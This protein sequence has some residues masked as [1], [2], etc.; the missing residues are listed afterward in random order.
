MA[1]N[2]GK[3]TGHAYTV[4]DDGKPHFG[5][6]PDDTPTDR[7]GRPADPDPAEDRA[8]KVSLPDDHDPSTPNPDRPTLKR[9]ST[10]VN[11][12]PKQKKEKVTASVSQAPPDPSKDDDRPTLKHKDSNHPDETSDVPPDPADLGSRK[13]VRGAAGTVSGAEPGL[14]DASRPELRRGKPAVL[15]ANAPDLQA[16]SKV[17]GMPADLKQA[18]AI[19]DA[20]SR[21]AHD[22]H[23]SFDS[24]ATRATTLANIKQL[25]LAVLADP[26]LA[27]DATEFS[28]PAASAASAHS[29]T[30]AA[31]RRTGARAGSTVSRTRPAQA[32]AAAASMDLQDEQLAAYQLTFSA[33]PTFVYTAHTSGTGSPA[34]FVTVIAQ[35]DP[36]GTLQPGFRSVTDTAHLDRTPRYRLVDAV[37]PDASNRASLLFEV[38]NQ[39][40]RQFALYRL[41]GPKPDQIFET[42]T[43]K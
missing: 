30:T 31:Q 12:G 14:A 2:D 6:K 28:K 19:S 17:V 4:Q 7:H 26:K 1:K 10:D 38:R 22:F 21:P 33:P 15:A 34:R 37:D 8:E 16:V 18:V 40:S 29:N 24:D 42:G 27:T 36:D 35:Q 9:S 41:L 23:Y 25:A 13:S 3:S 20:A 39:S 32:S 43:I 5:A 11:G